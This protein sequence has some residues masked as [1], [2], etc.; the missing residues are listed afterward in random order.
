MTNEKE[1]LDS[2][3]INL[4]ALR[5]QIGYKPS[6]FEMKINKIISEQYAPV[7]KECAERCKGIS[8]PASTVS[9]SGDGFFNKLGK[10]ANRAAKNAEEIE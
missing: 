6:A 8:H 1:T 3:H 9:D 10:W 2:I 7:C 5:L 4:H